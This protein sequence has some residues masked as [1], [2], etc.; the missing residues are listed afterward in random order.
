ME[1]LAGL[2]QSSRHG[3]DFVRLECGV[4]VQ[5]A[6][7]RHWLTPNVA[8][9]SR[10][11]SPSL[12]SLQRPA[13]GTIETPSLR[14]EKRPVP[15]S[16]EALGIGTW[17]R[18]SRPQSS[19][20]EMVQPERHEGPRPWSAITSKRPRPAR[21]PSADRRGNPWPIVLA[22]AISTAPQ[23]NAAFDEGDRL[24]ARPE[25]ARR[26]A[27]TSGERQAGTRGTPVNLPHHRARSDAK[28][29]F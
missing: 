21:H 26:G 12:P 19:A 22:A 8:G 20:A 1:G 9:G 15:F 29:L 2:L 17:F 10:S 5:I 24:R 18:S 16:K 14:S 7:Y 11:P 28:I 6:A 3:V 13:T 25:I 4:V 27:R 23:R